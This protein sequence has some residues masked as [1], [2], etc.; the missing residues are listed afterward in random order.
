MDFL[1]G[2]SGR[3]GRGGWWLGQL[4]IWAILIVALVLAVTDIGPMPKGATGKQI[5][6]QIS[7]S[8]MMALVALIALSTWISIAVTVKRFHD[9]NKPGIWFL[10]SFVPYIGSL[11]ILVECGMLAGTDGPNDYDDRNAERGWISGPP[12]RT[13]R[14]EAPPPVYSRAEAAPSRRPTGPT[15]F[16]RR[17]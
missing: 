12:V 14:T 6:R 11:W 9:R 1:F 3:V 10:I 8:T 16:G 15:G 7:G 2:F 17:V 13:S 5:M 4:A